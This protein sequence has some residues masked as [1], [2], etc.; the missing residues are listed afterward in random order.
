VVYFPNWAEA[1]FDLSEVAPAEEI[2][3]IPASFSV[4][5]AG[6][7][8]DAQDFPAIL[9][10]AQSLRSQTHI[11]WLFVGDGRMAQWVAD[12]IRLQGLRDCVAMVGRHP[13]ERMP[14]FFKHADALLVSLKDEPIFAMTIPGKLQSYLAAGIPVLAM[15]N[16]EGAEVVAA[17]RCGLVCPAGDAAGLAANVLSLSKMSKEERVAMGERGLATSAR[18][19]DRARLVSALEAELTGL[20][21][22]REA[23]RPGGEGP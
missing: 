19:F 16:G 10:A 2:P 18:E 11:R 8:G 6:N 5:F 23:H 12:E 21:R 13:V 14:S 1:I 17:S 7:I 22:A 4:M 15:L 9:A 3:A 20:V